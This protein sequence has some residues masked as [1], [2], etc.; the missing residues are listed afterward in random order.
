MQ[1]TKDLYGRKQ[2]TM[3][4]LGATKHAIPEAQSSTSPFSSTYRFVLRRC[5]SFVGANRSAER[6][7]AQKVAAVATAVCSLR[8]A[9]QAVPLHETL[10]RHLRQSWQRF[11]NVEKVCCP[12]SVHRLHLGTIVRHELMVPIGR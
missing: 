1:T 12:W 3:H 6:S 8:I 4:W 7:A 11:Q 9:K 5:Y 10:H 2:Y